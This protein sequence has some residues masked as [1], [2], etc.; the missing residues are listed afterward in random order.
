EQSLHQLLDRSMKS[1]TVHDQSRYVFRVS[2]RYNES[3]DN[4]KS[5]IVTLKTLDGFEVSLDIPFD[6]CRALGVSLHHEGEKAIETQ[7]PARE[8][9]AHHRDEL[10][11]SHDQLPHQGSR[12]AGVGPRARIYRLGQRACIR[13]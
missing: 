13:C 6:A 1:R 11:E 7:E 9:V 3:T 12:R 10:N 2:E 4:Q 5:L 8:T